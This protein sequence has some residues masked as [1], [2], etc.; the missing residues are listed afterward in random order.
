MI[1]H[2]LDVPS[3]FTHSPTEGHIGC[4]Q[5]GEIINKAATNNYTQF[6]C[7]CG[8]KF[9][10]PLGKYQCIAEMYAKSI[11]SFVRNYQTGFQSG[12]MILHPQ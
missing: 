3:L 5:F 9:S 6:F 12:W 4:F 11:L 7:V 2:F 10:T 8:R 1:F